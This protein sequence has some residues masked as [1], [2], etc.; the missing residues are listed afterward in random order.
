MATIETSTAADGTPSA[1]TAA[2]SGA[3][4]TSAP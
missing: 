1:T 2:S 4:S 3:G